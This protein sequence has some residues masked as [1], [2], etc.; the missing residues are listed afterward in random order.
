MRL[1][2]RKRREEIRKKEMLKQE[3]E[4]RHQLETQTVVSNLSRWLA[5]KASQV[6]MSKDSVQ[7]AKFATMKD[8]KHMPTIKL[9]TM[10]NDINLN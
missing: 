10:P 4:L 8:I 7:Y 1:N 2:K 6:L 3:K 5:K 9:V